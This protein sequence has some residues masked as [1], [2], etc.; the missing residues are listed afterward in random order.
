MLHDSS[1]YAFFV[2]ATDDQEGP[3][4]AVTNVTIHVVDVND[5]KPQFANDTYSFQ[6]YENTPLSSGETVGQVN[7]ID[8]DYGST[9]PVRPHSM[10]AC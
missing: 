1:V 6:F 2:Y 4:F 7:A 8:A 5:N 9:Q 3:D 10:Q